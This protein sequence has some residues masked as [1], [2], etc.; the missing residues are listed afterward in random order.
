M[1]E[2]RIK[3]SS[4]RSAGLRVVYALCG[5][6][7]CLAASCD[8]DP[9]VGPAPV[10]P[11]T[12]P[13]PAIEQVWTREI[14]RLDGYS[15]GISP[16]P[17]D[18]GEIVVVLHAGDSLSNV[19]YHFDPESG[20]VVDSF[21]IDDPVFGFGDITEYAPGLRIG[22]DYVAKVDQWP[23]RL[24][25]RDGSVRWVL[26]TTYTWGSVHGGRL[27][28]ERF[29][30]WGQPPLLGVIDLETGIVVDSIGPPPGYDYADRKGGYD[31]VRAF[32][33]PDGSGLVIAATLHS[34]PRDRLRERDWEATRYAFDAET[35]EILWAHR[36][37]HG[38]YSPSP[39][40]PVYF[41]GIL[42]QSV[43]DTVYGYDAR[44][45]EERWAYHFKHTPFPSGVETTTRPDNRGDAQAVGAS[46]VLDEATGTACFGSLN[47]FQYCLEVATGREVWRGGTGSGSFGSGMALLGDGLLSN[48]RGQRLN[49]LDRHTGEVLAEARRV[50]ARGDFFNAPYYDPARR[51]LVATDGARA[52]GYRVNVEP[53]G[54]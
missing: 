12:E 15:T 16:Q 33:R 10:D 26:S 48:T 30:D 9:P 40:S 19:L 23:F 3:L 38:A 44:T 22:D 20:A 17:I 45:G 41:D 50:S 47:S 18:D 32:E 14:H 42:A 24:S 13:P 34:I 6:L 2:V 51:L 1:T 29:T 46:P 35:H 25:L 27:Y 4:C 8:D 31:A 43:Y 39:H 28:A 52:I 37:G 36:I 53:P 7:V 54:E 11:T 49:L 5:K 21:L